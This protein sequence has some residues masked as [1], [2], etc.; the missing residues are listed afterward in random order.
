LA[1]R[2]CHSAA[3]ILLRLFSLRPAPL[4]LREAV[5]G[6]RSKGAFA[7][8]RKARWSFRSPA[9]TQRRAPR[10]PTASLRFARHG[11]VKGRRCGRAPSIARADDIACPS[12]AFALAII[13]LMITSLR[14][15][16]RRRI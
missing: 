6:A 14:W 4:C 9:A 12:S 16:R 11:R 8:R 15:H 3:V 10:S 5:R 2:L 7:P 1:A 13:A